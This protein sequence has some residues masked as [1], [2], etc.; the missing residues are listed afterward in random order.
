MTQLKRDILERL[1]DDSTLVTPELF[2]DAY[3]EIKRLREENEKMAAL[4][5]QTAAEILARR[6]K[7]QI[8]G[9]LK[10]VEKKEEV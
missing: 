9:D 4:L 2:D 10:I 7:I 5:T 8:E 6:L 3:D 1:G